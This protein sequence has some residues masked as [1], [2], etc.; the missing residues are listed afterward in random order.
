MI[1]TAPNLC[2][3]SYALTRIACLKNL[4]SINLLKAHFY[5]AINDTEHL[6]EM[7]SRIGNKFWVDRFL[8]MHLLL[9]LRGNDFLLLT[10]AIK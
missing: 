4:L 2:F 10:I 5:Q 8:S 6:E 7:E 3:V 9:L 1:D